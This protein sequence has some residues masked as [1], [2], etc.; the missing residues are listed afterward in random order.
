M[1]SESS[2]SYWSIFSWNTKAALSENT[3]TISLSLAPGVEHTK[4]FLNITIKDWSKLTFSVS[5]SV[6]EYANNFVFY[7]DIIKSGKISN[8][9]NYPSQWLC[10]H[11]ILP[12]QFCLTLHLKKAILLTLMPNILNLPEIVTL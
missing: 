10:R 9:T 11:K 4:K 7:V 1:A 5:F 8:L 6:P 12:N 2:S 3:S